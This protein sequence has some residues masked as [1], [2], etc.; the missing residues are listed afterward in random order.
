MFK[1]KWWLVFGSVLALIV[2]NGTINVFAVGIFF[3]PI[4]RDLGYGRGIISTAVGVTNICTALMVPFFGRLLDKYGVRRILLPAIVLF[5]LTT[6]ARSLITSS[7]V[8]LFLIF[9]IGGFAGAGQ[10][11]TPYSKLI[12]ERFDTQ[13]GLALGIVL[14]GVGLGT[15]IVPQYATFLL[16]HFGWRVGFLGLGCLIIIL[17]FIPAAVFCREPVRTS[18]KKGAAR[19]AILGTE[20][21]EAVRTFQFW[22]IWVIFFFATVAINGSLI[23]VVPMLTDRGLPVAAATAALSFSGIALIGGRLL[24]GYLLDKIYAP[25]IGIFFLLMPMIGLAILGMGYRGAGPVLGTVLLG[26]GMGAEIDLLAYIIAAYFGVRAFG[27][28]H[29]FIFMGALLA[30][31]VGAAALGWCYQLTKSYSI[32]FIAFE[33][34]LAISVVLFALLGPYRF[35]VRKHLKGAAEVSRSSEVKVCQ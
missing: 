29:G 7:V 30:N 21:S 6:A 19:A 32:G 12:A 15:A 34:I 33:I 18:A 9:A 11:T 10:S 26:M 17:A 25:Y 13:R 2:G 24:S 28:I 27:A 23:H 20:F 31:A 1:N 14:S 16:R 35:P 22:A 4:A 3:K 5:A 8:V